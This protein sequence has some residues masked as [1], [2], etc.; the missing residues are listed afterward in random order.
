MS[1]FFIDRP[2]FAWVLSIVI[3][4]G[5]RRDAPRPADRPVPADR[6]AHDPGDDQLIP[7]ASSTTVAEP[8]ASRSKS[9]S[10][11]C[12][13]MIYM[14]ST[15]T[16]NGDYTLTV[17]FEVGT[18]VIHG[19]DA[20]ADAHAAR[21]AAVA[22]KRAEA[23]R[24]RQDRVAQYPPR[25]QPHL[26]RRPLFDPLY[27]SNLRAR[28]T[29]STNCRG[30][31]GVGLVTFLGQREYSMRAWLDPQKMA[32]AG[33]DRQRSHGRHSRT[34]TSSWRR[35]TS[36]SSRCPGAGFTSSCS[37]RW[38]GSP[39]PSNS[40]TSSSRSAGTAAWFTCADVAR[41]DTRGA[42]NSDLDCTLTRQGERQAGPLPVGG[43]GRLFA[44]DRQRARRLAGQ[45]EEE[46]GRAQESVS[47]RDVDFQIAY[48]TTPFIEHSVDDV[49]V[50]STSP[51]AWSSSSSWSFSRTGGRCCCRSSTSSW[52]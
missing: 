18:D 11:A 19:P 25:R 47:R 30:I 10:T 8:S 52:P 3:V 49:I 50:R 42:Q 28:S 13:G 37:T 35:A 17:S 9:K 27:L 46:D 31:P 12:E 36:A 1:R 38:A 20:G 14:S 7:A 22:R 23:G 33:H 21:P 26:A 39:R 4:A 15:C 34:R 6:A 40:A 24:Q 51:P 45:S 2:V 29:S 48:D 16:N 41:L 5:R 43:H 44:A 32:V